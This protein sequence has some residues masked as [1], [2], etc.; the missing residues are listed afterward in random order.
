MKVK[1]LC[2][3]AYIPRS[4]SRTGRGGPTRTGIV[5]VKGHGFGVRRMALRRRPSESARGESRTHTMR[6]L[7]PLPLPVGLRAP[8]KRDA[9]GEIRTHKVR[10]LRTACLPFAPLPPTVDAGG[11]SRT[12]KRACGPRR[13]QRR[14]S[15]CSATP[16]RAP[17]P[18][19]GIEPPLPVPK[20]G[21]ATVRLP[22]N[23]RRTRHDSNVR[24]QPPQGCALIQLSYGSESSRQ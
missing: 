22:R 1:L 11:G 2:P 19:E 5:P 7:S 16:A 24:P 9:G 12:L 3:F 13:P 6:V 21:V 10:L 14:A 15:A 23:N 18:G 17:T 20:T 4:V 8:V